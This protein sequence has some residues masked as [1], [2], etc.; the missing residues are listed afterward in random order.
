MIPLNT[1]GDP[2]NDS[3]LYIVKVTF[4][5]PD[6]TIVTDQILDNTAALWLKFD[7]AF[8]TIYGIPTS[9]DL[10]KVFSNY[11]II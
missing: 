8:N 6:G 1:F 5:K 4:T 7:N 9:A 10:I 11:F 3:L 2:D